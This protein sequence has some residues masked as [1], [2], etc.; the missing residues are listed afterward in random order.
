MAIIYEPKGR[1]REYSSLAV[2][3]YN[4]CMH[5][6]LYCYAPRCLRRDKSIYH[7]EVTVKQNILKKIEKDLIRLKKQD[8]DVKDKVLF[9][10]TCDPY[11]GDEMS[12]STTRKALELF[13]KYD[14]PFQ[15]LTKGGLKAVRDFD[16]YTKHDAFAVTLTFYDE[17]KSLFY[18]P[19]AA[20]PKDRIKA[21]QIAK[22]RGIE[23]WVSFEPVLNDEEIFRL[24]KLTYEWVDV[25][26]IGKVSQFETDKPIDWRKF[27]YEI[28]DLCEKNMK[29]YYLKK[30]LRACL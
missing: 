4:G 21:L 7:K 3:L 1:A 18:E 23:T 5:G 16:L 15:V 28:V 14:V 20:L 24:F 17:K 22:K 11:Q 12:N 6:C 10:F 13:R 19:N 2:N 27:A 29:R 8:V 25:Y 30:D 26:K 9:C